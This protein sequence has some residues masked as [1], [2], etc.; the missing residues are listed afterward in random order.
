MN[1]ESKEHEA[2]L[3]ALM[4]I[5]AGEP[6]RR[7]T[8][9]AVRR[10]VARRRRVA[11]A[12]TAAALVMIG[13]VGVA[14]AAQRAEGGG[15]GPTAPVTRVHSRPLR[16]PGNSGVPRYYVV[17]TVIPNSGNAANREETTV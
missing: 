1:T 8:V 17:R 9:D 6:Q 10:R 4:D 15:H 7:V 2:K 11:S 13:G 5:A 3:R 16:V 14:I 12:V